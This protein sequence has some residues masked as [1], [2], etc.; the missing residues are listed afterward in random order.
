MKITARQASRET[1]KPG[2]ARRNATYFFLLSFPFLSIFFSIADKLFDSISLRQK[3]TF[4]VRAH[5]TTH[6]IP[7]FPAIFMLFSFSPRENFNVKI[8]ILFL[9][10]WP[11][12]EDSARRHHLCGP[13]RKVPNFPKSWL[14]WLCSNIFFFNFYLV[15][16]PPKQKGDGHRFFLT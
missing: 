14:G 11:D 10:R 8:P 9:F 13:R 15:E 5:V 7:P 1:G 12:N 2:A 6:S 3:K 4:P 16:N